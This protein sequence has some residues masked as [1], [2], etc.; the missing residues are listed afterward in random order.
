MKRF[1]YNLIIML[2]ITT[3]IAGCNKDYLNAKTAQNLAVPATLQDFQAL[4]DSNSTMNYM[5]PYLS[6]LASDGHYANDAFL[7]TLSNYRINAYTWSN[8]NTYP[9][10]GIYDWTTLYKC[11]YYSNLVLEGLENIHPAS[12]T[13]QLTWNNLKG[14]ALF[15]RANSFYELAKQWA[16]VYDSANANTDL[17]IVLR[18][19]SDANVPQVR[20]TVQQT[21]DQVINDLLAAKRLLSIT[22]AYKTRASQPATF[23]LLARIYLAKRD[24][25]NAGLYAD[26]CLQLSNS[27]L[28]YNTLNS[29]ATYPFPIFNNEVIFHFDMGYDVSVTTSCLI[30]STL[31]A[32]YATNDLRKQLFFKTNSDGT[33]NFKGMYDN[34]EGGANFAGLAVDEMYLIR[35]ECYA[36]A[37][38]TSLAMGDLNTLLK[39]RW[40]NTVLFPT[41]TATDANDAL[42]QILKE[43]K[44]ELILRGLR[45]SD[46]KRLNK[47]A[48][49]TI[50]LTREYKGTIYTL[51]PNSYQY[52]FPIPVDIMQLSGIQQNS[53]W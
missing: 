14:C 5:G 24:Y 36:R 15:D 43:R 35:A 38:Y 17:G 41:Y 1:Y 40:K 12:N 45:W 13:D 27:L 18:L 31:Y 26:S 32:S 37:G 11:V 8:F 16:P 50:T 23:A 29:S 51:S 52:T 28:D 30:D 4:I 3:F 34:L 25:T 53:R 21:Y 42:N 46:L 44:K 49:F 2:S 9:Y 10:T 48:Q 47:E 6:E 33:H 22:A 7:N 20:S 19:S 39:T